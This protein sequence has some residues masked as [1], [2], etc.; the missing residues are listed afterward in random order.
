MRKTL[1]NKLL[2]CSD[3]KGIWCLNGECLLKGFW[4]EGGYLP[5]VR[6]V[7]LAADS[8][9]RRSQ[10]LLSDNPKCD[11]CRTTEQLPGANGGGAS[12]PERWHGDRELGNREFDRIRKA[13]T[14][15]RS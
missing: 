10:R 7:S 3:D 15:V 11:L 1:N 2:S 4:E 5:S 14:K 6:G 9:S 13:L 8:Q 12:P